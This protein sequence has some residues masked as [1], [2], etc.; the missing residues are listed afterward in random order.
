MHLSILGRQVRAFLEDS[1]GRFAIHQQQD[2]AEFLGWLLR[3]LAEDNP[4]F[5]RMFEL[6]VQSLYKCRA[7]H[8][9]SLHDEH[10]PFILYG[11]ERSASECF[12]NSLREGLTNLTCDDCQGSLALAE[13][14]ILESP[15]Y[16]LISMPKSDRAG[17]KAL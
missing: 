10:L 7:G 11:Q 4:L 9:R 8:S 16:L 12:R 13:K 17:S 15:A 3:A 5:E 14:K 2:A 6:R 1:R